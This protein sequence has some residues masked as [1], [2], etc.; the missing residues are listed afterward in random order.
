MKLK[1]LIY[2]SALLTPI[3]ATADTLSISAGGGLWNESPSGTFNKISD[4]AAVNVE[5]DLFWD[6]ESQGYAFITF[7]HFVPLIPNVKIMSTKIDH[8]G[9]GNAN[10]VYDGNTYTGNISNDM[11]I[12]E[13]DLYLYYELL[14]NVV[15]FDLGL[16]IRNLKADYMITDGTTTDTNSINETIPM[17]YALVGGSP[18]PDLI[19]SGEISYMSL[20]GNKMSDFTAKIA[21]TT[22]FFVGFE[23]GYR[24]QQITLDDVSGTNADLSFKGAFAGAYIK[25]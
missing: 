16:N 10:F 23:A 25:F 3:T 4:P 8:S 6:A 18:W 2:I 24:N 22:S 20:Q 5:S 11:S 13:L 1:N 21:Y 7:E 9:S 19:L 12:S 15:S 17:V 14:D